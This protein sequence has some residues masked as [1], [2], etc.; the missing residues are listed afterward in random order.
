[1]S[2]RI[3]VTGMGAITPLGCGVEQVWR[4]LLAGQSGIRS[5][6]E[7]LIGE[8]STTI[9]GQVPD[10]LQDPE[11]GF[12][13]DQ[14]LAPKEQRK[15]DRFI[16]FALAAA[17]EALA[18]AGWKPDTAEAQE[19]TAT[20][21]ASGVGGFPAIAEAV[22]TTDSKGPR[23]LS[24]FTIPSFLSNMA[25]GH[26]SI[27][28]G[29]KGPLG[30]PVTACAA[31]VQA[32]GDA[33]R[34]IRAGEIDIAVCGGAEAAIHRVSLGGFAAARALSSEFNDT[35]ERASRPFDQAR[36]GF[37]MGEG[38]GLLVIEE[39]EHA[40]ARGARP[41]A[42]LVGYGT[43]A[44]AYH[45]TA[46]PEDGDGARRAMQQ[47]LRQAGIQASQVQHLNAHATS[48]PVGDKGELAAIRTVFGT[49]SG[50]AISATKSATGHLLGAAGGI[51][52]IFTILALRDQIAPATLN[53][54][55]PDSAAAGLDLV[56]GQARQ[57]A[58]QY[59]L[60]NGFG[61]GGVNASVLFKRWE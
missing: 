26:V 29:L 35:P 55:N 14:L 51:E 9:G 13:P 49:N 61:F 17:E 15:M 1:M 57:L 32:I 23:R 27:R 42:E 41:I 53:L 56:R 45:M 10:S 30:A 7:E 4:R 3:V 34:M 39:L 47:A 18:Q 36:D 28:H 40:L 54:E 20:I 31:G 43:S 21:I 59:A 22:R 38:A 6:P 52:A 33:A 58:M 16:L 44:D 5:L 19:R 8:L 37:V 2:K 60:S 12:D 50:L 24:P 25:A 48:T 46:G 11:A